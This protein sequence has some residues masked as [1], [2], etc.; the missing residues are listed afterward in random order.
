M[1]LLGG[2]T[3]DLFFQS[4]W[5]IC[6]V[7]TL[8]SGWWR[9]ML[10]AMLR[11]CLQTPALQDCAGRTCSGC[12]RAGAGVRAQECSTLSGFPARRAASRISPS[13]VQQ[14]GQALLQCQ[15]GCQGGGCASCVACRVHVVSSRWLHLRQVPWSKAGAGGTWAQLV[16]AAGQPRLR[17]C[18]V[19]R[20]R[21]RRGGCGGCSSPSLPWWL[22]GPRHGSLDLAKRMVLG[23]LP[24]RVTAMW[25]SAFAGCSGG[26]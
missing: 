8:C 7:F 1:N 15:A 14:P 11:G 22:H 20:L 6:Q 24:G 9:L 10:S 12:S 25:W 16:L 4:C 5:Y 13:L 18:W 23:G 2:A 19:L 17:L 26:S 3:F 21:L